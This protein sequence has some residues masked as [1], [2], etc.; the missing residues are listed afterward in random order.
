RSCIGKEF[1][2]LTEGWE[3]ERRNMIKGLSDNYLPVIFPWSRLIKNT[4]IP[5]HA[6]SHGKN[7]IVGRLISA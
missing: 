5:V 7:C 1:L 4:I 2:V 3:S 6:E